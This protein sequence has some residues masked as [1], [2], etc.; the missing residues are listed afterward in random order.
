MRQRWVSKLEG[1]QVIW[2]AR[3]ESSSRRLS[4]GICHAGRTTMRAGDE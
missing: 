3:A 2:L 4:S 1:R